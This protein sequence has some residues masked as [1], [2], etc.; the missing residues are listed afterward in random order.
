MGTFDFPQLEEKFFLTLNEPEEIIFTIPASDLLKE[1][2]MKHLIGTYG[3]LIQAREC[4]ATAAFFISWYA[5]VC[6]ALQHMLYRGD[7][8]VLDLSLSKLSVQLYNCGPYPRFS[9]K[10]NELQYHKAPIQNRDDWIRELLDSFYRVNITPVIQSLAESVQMNVIPLWGQ[11]VN[12]MYAQ[13]EEELA[14]ASDEKVWKRIISHFE[15]LKRGV[16]SSA[17]GLR[18]NPFD[19]KR[20]FVEHPTIPDQKVAIKTAC[21]LACCLNGDFGYCYECPRLK[22]KDRAFMRVNG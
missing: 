10:I 12:T 16:M 4:S 22:E 14:G 13:I 9:F 1:E 20:I 11:I 19:I 7:E 17:F 5:G 15:L 21:C 6:G 3:M 18:K 2:S 8:L